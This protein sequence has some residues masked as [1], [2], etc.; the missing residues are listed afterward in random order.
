MNEFIVQVIEVKFFGAR[1]DVSVLIKVAF[2]RLIDACDECE[3]AEV[4][5]ATVDQ[6]W[7]INVFLN[8]KR[9]LIANIVHAARRLHKSPHIL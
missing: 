3:Y 7:V 4:E 9:L 1:T 2:E 6:E 5:F 8:N